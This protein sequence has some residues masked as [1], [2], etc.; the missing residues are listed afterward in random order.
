MYL[1]DATN[2]TQSNVAP[3]FSKLFQSESFSVYTNN[4][5]STPSTSST[6][7]TTSQSNT[8]M[9]SH[10]PM[11]SHS[12]QNS[13]DSPIQ[14]L[15]LSNAVQPSQVAKNP[16]LKLTIGS[17]IENPLVSLSN[18]STN[19][20]S[21]T[22]PSNPP[23]TSNAS[24]LSSSMELFLSNASTK[25]VNEFSFSPCGTYLAVVSQDGFLRVFTFIYHNNQ[26]M[27][28]QLKCS[29]KSYFGGLLCV[30]WS[31]DG[32]YIATG[33]EDDL[34]TVFSFVNMRVACRGRGHSSWI[35]CCAF[36][37]WTRLNYSNNLN[38]KNKKYNTKSQVTITP[39]NQNACQA[40]K[41]ID[42]TVT[43]KD[44]IDNE[45]DLEEYHMKN[46]QQKIK[47]LNLNNNKDNKNLMCTPKK[48]TISTLS[49]FGPVLTSQA[50]IKSQKSKR[51]STSVYYRL[52]SCGQDNQICFWDL[53]DDVLK[54]KSH[55]PQH[56]NSTR[57]Q[58]GAGISHKSAFN[59]N[60]A[61]VNSSANHSQLP[62]IIIQP[63]DLLNKKTNEIQPNTQINQYLQQH[64]TQSNHKHHHSAASS[65][66]STA[67]SLFT[68]SKHNANNTDEGSNGTFIVHYIKII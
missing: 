59:T 2:Q 31:P 43:E 44:E 37:P 25:S 29:M 7:T 46:T 62:Q 10:K 67:K 61:L 15:I 3:V 47:T 11:S 4:N 21:T 8:P 36:D 49:D 33:G 53:T 19:N 66:V 17:T 40:A 57:S 68:S 26:Q 55:P 41:K 63:I 28:I 42:K 34:I 45:S 51:N 16:V 56:T 6:S 12:S 23:A 39:S 65:I 24:S 32:R 30:S 52:A 13:N 1:Y 60:N 64:Q 38:G 22:G 50:S 48:R 18:S 54:E 20:N 5:A 14:T 27:R 58:L 35:N 9:P